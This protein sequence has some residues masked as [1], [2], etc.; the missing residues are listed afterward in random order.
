M[1]SLDKDEWAA[2][3]PIV[4][5][6]LLGFTR[7]LRLA[8][9]VVGC[10]CTLTAMS[11][12]ATTKWTKIDA[13]PGFSGWHKELQRLTDKEGSHRINHFCVVVERFHAP[14]GSSDTKQPR[15]ESLGHVYW[16]EGSRL[17]TWDASSADVDAT[18]TRPGNDLDL[19]KDVRATQTEIGTSTYLVTR[20]WVHS[21]VQHCVSDGLQLTV[22]KGQS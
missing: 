7:G 20:A 16:R 3:A 12:A 17:I 1:I 8:A 19:K 15:E 4:V 18:S 14:R 11:S 9:W 5:N 22:I 6:R 21:I 13:A 2:S 10:S